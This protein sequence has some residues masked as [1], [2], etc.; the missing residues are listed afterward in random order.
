MSTIQ[1][2]VE[3]IERASTD[4]DL[5]SIKQAL[6]ALNLRLDAGH[7]LDRRADRVDQLA[8]LGQKRFRAQLPG[9]VVGQPVFIEDCAH[10]LLQTLRRARGGEAKVEQ[11]ANFPW[12][13]V[14]RAGARVH[15]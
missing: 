7:V 2:F 3:Q 8:T 9:Y 11:N 15:V 5:A 10:A 6:H 13:D 1:T 4:G 14:G 12:D